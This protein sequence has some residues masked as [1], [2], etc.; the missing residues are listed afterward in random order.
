MLNCLSFGNWAMKERT[1]LL[2]S[3]VDFVGWLSL[4]NFIGRLH[5]F[6]SLVTVGKE[7]ELAF[8]FWTG[9]AG[10]NAMSCLS[11]IRLWPANPELE[12]QGIGRSSTL[13]FH[14]HSNCTLIAFW[15]HFKSNSKLNSN[16]FQNLLK[17]H[18][19]FHREHF[20]PKMVL[21]MKHSPQWMNCDQST[22]DRLLVRKAWP[23]LNR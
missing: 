4:A 16:C 5:W 13:N 21:R 12:F 7:R 18:P 10:S 1:A 3:L 2:A 15:L 22:G 17:L 23:K 11:S 9:F 20:N 8:N 19:N 14:F 6:T